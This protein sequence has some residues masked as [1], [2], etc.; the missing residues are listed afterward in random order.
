MNDILRA[1]MNV[2][3]K[4]L[5]GSYLLNKPLLLLFTLGRCQ[6]QKD[7]LAPFS[8]YEDACSPFLMIS[9]DS[10]LCFRSVGYLQI[11]FEK[12]LITLNCTEIPQVTCL[13]QS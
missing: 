2:R 10:I 3:V 1:F 8:L 11:E 5:E 12:S 7:R 9:V 6:Q 13:D 4:R